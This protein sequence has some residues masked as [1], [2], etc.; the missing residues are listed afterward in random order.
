MYI[1]C[2]ITTTDDLYFDQYVLHKLLALNTL[3][4]FP[5]TQRGCGGTDYAA[6]EGTGGAAALQPQ[7]LEGP[8]EDSI[9]RLRMRAAR[10]LSPMPFLMLNNSCCAKAAHCASW[11]LGK[12]RR[13]GG[14]SWHLGKGRR[15]GGEQ[16]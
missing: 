15:W 9:M 7:R 14:D 3:R 2:Y 10:S 5:P 12:G 8:R 16:C 13:W 11:H 6:Q 4:L 1:A